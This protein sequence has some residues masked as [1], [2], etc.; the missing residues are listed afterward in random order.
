MIFAWYYV[1][2]LI[3]SAY[4]SR[5]RTKE[6]DIVWVLVVIIMCPL[7]IPMMVRE[8]LI[9]IRLQLMLRKLKRLGVLN[10]ELPRLSELL[11]ENLDHSDPT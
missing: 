4:R 1:I 3:Y 10:I 8:A 7:E 6:P 2:S 11:L 5:F 9:L